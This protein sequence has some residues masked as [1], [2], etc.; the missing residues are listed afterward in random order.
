MSSDDE[1]AREILRAAWELARQQW[2]EIKLSFEEYEACVR[3]KHRGK[4][5]TP[6]LLGSLDLRALFL[7]CA[8]CRTGDATALKVLEEVYLARVPEQL[9]HLNL[10]DEQ[11]AELLQR[12]RVHLLMGTPPRLCM[13][14]GEGSL[15]SW[16]YVIAV[17]MAYKI[18]ETGRELPDDVLEILAARP[19][20]GPSPEQ[21]LIREKFRP[22]FLKALREVFDALPA[23]D[24]LLLRLS[25]ERGMSTPA[26]AKVFGKHQTTVWRALQRV[27]GEVFEQVKAL[28]Q[29]RLGLSSDSFESLLLSL[30]SQMDMRLSQV[31]RG[32]RYR[33][34]CSRSPP[35][36]TLRLRRKHAPWYLPKKKKKKKKN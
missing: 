29:R 27:Y 35:R 24:R 4:P 32:P 10:S 17:R 22:E 18:L 7:T 25:F 15:T 33:K 8:W 23:E 5:L 26:L 13:Y 31:L 30:R 2:P 6:E 36:L 21:A 1:R 16:L 19:A 34:P 12:L 9:R 28:L 20:P 11:R 14:K 3:E